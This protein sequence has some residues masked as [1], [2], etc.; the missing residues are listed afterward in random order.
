MSKINNGFI[1]VGFYVGTRAIETYDKCCDLVGFKR[2][3]R[4]KFGRQQLLYSQNATPEGYSVW[5]IAHSNLN[6]NFNRNKKWFNIFV[7]SETIKEIWLNPSDFHS[8]QSDKNPRVCFAKNNYGVYVFKGIYKA[9]ETE[10]E[11]I[12]G[13]VELVRTF[14]RISSTYPIEKTYINIETQKNI[15][16]ISNEYEEIDT[17]VNM[18]Q[19]KA[20]IIENKKETTIEVN[21]N[22]RPQQKTIIG[23]KVGEKFKFPNINLTYEI[24]KIFI[25]KKV[26]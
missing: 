11:E 24:K 7:D 22:S 3:H 2:A 15:N 20:Y 12:M 26:K 18:C 25:I 4:G 9:Q 8:S 5:M 6:E 13:K 17:V 10:Y 14:K 19:I 23:K 21:I 1:E 16:N